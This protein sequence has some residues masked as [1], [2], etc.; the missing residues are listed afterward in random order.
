MLKVTESS[1]HFT[2]TRCYMNLYEKLIAVIAA[3]TS[4]TSHSLET[5]PPTQKKNDNPPHAKNTSPVI[6]DTKCTS[7]KKNIQ[8]Q[9][10]SQSTNV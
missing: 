7:S 2:T 10:I 9:V 8:K 6:I 5:H 3:L 4:I 1:K